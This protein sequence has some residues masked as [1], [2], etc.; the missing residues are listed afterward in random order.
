MYSNSHDSGDAG[1]LQTVAGF[2]QGSGLERFDV[3]GL[4]LNEDVNDEYGVLR[5]P[6]A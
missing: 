3:I 5:S 6:P 1:F 4:D 2:F